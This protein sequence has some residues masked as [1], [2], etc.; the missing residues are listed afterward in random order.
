MSIFRIQ[1]PLST[2]HTQEKQDTDGHGVHFHE[3]G[4]EVSY[5]SHTVRFTRKEYRILLELYAAEGHVCSREELL[6]NVWGH[7]VFVDL[8]TIDR[9]VVQLR[10]KIKKISQQEL[11]IDTVWGIGYRLRVPSGISRDS[12]ESSPE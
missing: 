6:T 4:M 5:R 9:H 11:H 1:A 7:K 3:A 12:M 10:R 2:L 8:R